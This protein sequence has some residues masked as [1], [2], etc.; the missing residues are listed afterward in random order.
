LLQA[1]EVQRLIEQILQD[2]EIMAHPAMPGLTR[3]RLREAARAAGLEPNR[4]GRFS[5]AVLV[6]FACAGVTVLEDDKAP[7]DWIRPRPLVC[8]D[9]AEI[10]K[11]LRAVDP[12]DGDAVAI[13]RAAGLDSAAL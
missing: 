5:G 4:F 3:A 8:A 11:L 10:R 7:N 9:R 6:W 1:D 12:P 2:T 13:A